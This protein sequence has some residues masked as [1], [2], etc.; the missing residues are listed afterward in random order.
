LPIPRSRSSAS[1]CSGSSPS[2]RRALR[3]RC[4]RC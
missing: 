1:S 3:A 4:S 2:R